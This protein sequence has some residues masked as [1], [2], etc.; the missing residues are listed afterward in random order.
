MSRKKSALGRG[1]DAL[2][3][4]ALSAVHDA[5]EAPRDSASEIA[6]ERIKPGRFQPRRLFDAQ[7]L[8]ELAASIQSQGM[9]QPIVVRPV[10]DG[11]EIIAGER[12]WR[13]AQQAGLRMV[14]AVVR[15]LPDQATMAI[16]LIEN[17]QRE[18]LTPL[19][20]ARA[21][22]RLIDEFSLTHQ[23]AA[24]AVGRSRVA[25]SNLVRL[26]E[27]EPAVCALMDEGLLEMGH[28]RALLSL[29]AGEQLRLGK[30]AVEQG[31]SVRE[32]ES[33]VRRAQSAAPTP[34]LSPS[35]RRRDPNLEQLE[36]ELS[37]RLATPVAIANR[38]GRGTLTI[39]YSSLDELDG[40]LSRIR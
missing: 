17:I 35:A 8:S 5:A 39:R 24:D 7:K 27:L 10:A 16:A 9:V 25:V 1:L 2:L 36:R 14:P 3:G 38:G 12:R 21:V 29:S 19:E 15:D 11:Y 40:L 4:D 30:L 31:W 22:K 32:M 23:Q 28:A 18:D 33:Q 26:L 34:R 13:A 20:E 37:E 6:I